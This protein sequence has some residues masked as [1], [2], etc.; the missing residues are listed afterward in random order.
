MYHNDSFY[1]VE[2]ALERCVFMNIIFEYDF[3]VHTICQ[4]QNSP[5]FMKC[6]SIVVHQ[7]FSLTTV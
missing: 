1:F 6:L 7:L 3:N 2:I 5:Y 4:R